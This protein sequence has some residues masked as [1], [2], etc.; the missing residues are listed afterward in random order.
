MVR[1]NMIEEPKEK[2]R[3]GLWVSHEFCLVCKMTKNGN[4]THYC[5]H[6]A[7]YLI[8]P[9]LCRLQLPLC[10]IPS[11]LTLMEK[12]LRPH[13]VYLISPT[14]RLPRGCVLTDSYALN[15][16]RGPI[17]LSTLLYFSIILT[18][19]LIT[20]ILGTKTKRERGRWKQADRHVWLS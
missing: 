7:S 10:D 16:A 19:G 5:L 4:S 13:V 15:K 6:L 1:N 11:E 20:W 12:Q 8:S 17:R 2:K 14:L 3:G 9:V 18:E